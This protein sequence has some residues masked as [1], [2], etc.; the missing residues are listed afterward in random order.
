MGRM[1]PPGAALGRQGQDS[2]AVSA[3]GTPPLAPAPLRLGHP[4]PHGFVKHRHPGCPNAERP[5]SPTGRP[6]RGRGGNRE[7]GAA[8][9]AATAP[10][11]GAW[12][13]ARGRGSEPP[14]RRGDSGRGVRARR[15]YR[16]QRRQSRDPLQASA[17]RDS[18]ASIGTRRTRVALLRI[19]SRGPRPRTVIG[20]WGKGPP[21]LSESS[22]P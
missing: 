5:R 8:E 14:V 15:P 11:A 6:T 17:H 19:P 1:A 12:P 2:S 3:G 10:G 4:A 20:R 21:D 7:A 22:T 16:Q 18:A 13:A 9:K